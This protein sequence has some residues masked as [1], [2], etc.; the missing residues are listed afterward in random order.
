MKNI[1]FEKKEKMGRQLDIQTARFFR[2]IGLFI[3]T[4]R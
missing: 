2:Q 1:D 4:D 3:F